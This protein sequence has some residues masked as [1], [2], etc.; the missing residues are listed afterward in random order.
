MQPCQLQHFCLVVSWR[1]DE[2]Q[3]AQIWSDAN[4]RC[5]GG[6]S[7]WVAQWWNE[8]DT[9]AYP[10]CAEQWPLYRCVCM[11]LITLQIT[12]ARIHIIESKHERLTSMQQKK[13]KLTN[14]RDSERSTYV[15]FFSHISTYD[16]ED[17]TAPFYHFIW[18]DSLF[19]SSLAG[20]GLILENPFSSIGGLALQTLAL[21][22]AMTSH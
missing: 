14:N 20:T 9:L 2:K 21:I 17:L 13:K 1:K 10:C 12:V 15:P 18:V 6:N 11:M 4:Q 8:N 16:R 7:S 22:Q 5:V 3:W 19:I